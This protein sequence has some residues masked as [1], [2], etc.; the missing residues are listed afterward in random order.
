MESGVGLLNFLPPGSLGQSVEPLDRGRPSSDV[1]A[2]WRPGEQLW[3]CIGTSESE[4]RAVAVRR[5]GHRLCGSA[6]R[7]R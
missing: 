4:Q 1:L 2:F 6:S 5:Q 7:H 3:T